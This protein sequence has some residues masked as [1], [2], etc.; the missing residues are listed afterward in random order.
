MRR[1]TTRSLAGGAAGIAAG[2][3]GGIALTAGSA[4]TI[5]TA[6]G[7]A[8]VD[9]AHFP[10]LLTLPGE[11]VTLRY[12][13]VCSPR[14]DGLPCEGSGEVHARAGQ[15]GPFRVFPLE[16]GADSAE[17]RYVVTLPLA[18]SGAGDGFSY[19]AILRDDS[20]GAEVTVPSGGAAAPQRSFPLR[21]PVAVH[22]GVHSFGRTRQADARVVEAP[23]G[24]GLGYAGLA[25]S[26]ERG[27]AG[28]SAFDV[29]PDGAVTLLD[30]VN[31]RL[32]RWSRGRL[33]S[34]PVD[35]TT[36]L[37]D[38]VVEPDGAANVLEPPDRTTP[39]SIL[40][41]FDRDGGHRWSLQLS[42]RTWAKLAAGPEGPVAL[43]EPSE[44]W[45]PLAVNGKPLDKAAQAA[46]GRPG[47]PLVQGRELVVERIDAGE[48]RLAELAGQRVARDWR[49]T[50]A[51]PLGE[52]QLAEA[53][54]D[55]LVA[56]VKA[57]TDTESE[58]VALVLDG[59]GA[60][61]T[62]SLPATEWAESAP[63]ARFRLSGKSLYRLGSTPTEAFVDRYD[64][65][66][67]S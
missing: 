32:E 7:A 56:V 3:C 30:Q 4:G 5:A 61:R 11:R 45:L 41:S 1:P 23:W 53:I 39:Y 9:A 54:G 51:T 57:Y 27:F 37:A 20:T 58:Y 46:R 55:E 28:P 17:G 66:V 10:P 65:E 50:S 25:G 2:I 43:E 19:Y 18:L 15:S 24:S 60:A 13:I 59:A 16:R 64:L 49:V 67:S 12:A 21:R 48:V 36:G 31:G 26:R 40:R 38:L 44:Q 42:D 14:D 47:K 63:L 22:L 35:V 34:T 33:S 8:R 29:R 62:M 52:V 6:P